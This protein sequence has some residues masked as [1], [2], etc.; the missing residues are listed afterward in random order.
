MS[1]VSGEPALLQM[2]RNGNKWKIKKKT[3]I[4]FPLYVGWMWCSLVTAASGAF[5]S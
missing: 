1:G 2:F 4:V 3:F 5:P